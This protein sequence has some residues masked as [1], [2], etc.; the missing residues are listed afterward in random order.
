MY[1]TGNLPNLANTIVL[2]LPLNWDGNKRS[3]NFGSWWISYTCLLGII[4]V[5]SNLQLNKDSARGQ[6]RSF[7][8]IFSGFFFF[9][10]FFFLYFAFENPNQMDSQGWY[11]WSHWFGS[12]DFWYSLW[13]LLTRETDFHYCI[14]SKILF[15]SPTDVSSS[16]GYMTW[17]KLS[18]AKTMWLWCI[19]LSKSKHCCYFFFSLTEKLRTLFI[20]SSLM[21]HLTFPTPPLLFESY[22]TVAFSEATVI[23]AIS[24]IPGADNRVKQA[25]ITL[26]W[27]PAHNCFHKCA[28]DCL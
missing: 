8:F 4:L 25:L 7:W 17:H 14:F 9:L 18:W 22:Q 26:L 21:T 27:I 23:S 20:I 24:S 6:H 12:N 15:L 3:L 10:F 16:L 5:Q 13:K 19:Y 11:S 1:C 2:T 28:S